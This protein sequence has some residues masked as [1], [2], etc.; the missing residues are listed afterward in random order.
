MESATLLVR[1]ARQLLTLHGPREPRR[2]AA[3]RE[4]GIIPNGAVLMRDGLIEQVGPTR[5]VVN[6]AAARGA[7][8]IDAGGRI[9]LP[10]FVD[11]HTHLVH[12]GPWLDD[13]EAR[14]AGADPLES[15]TGWKHGVDSLRTTS[16]RRLEAQAQATLDGI[17]RHGTTTVEAKSGYGSDPD[18]DVKVL[19]VLARLDQRPLDVL[20]T[21]LAMGPLWPSGHGRPSAPDLDRLCAQYLPAVARRKIAAG[22]ACSSNPAPE[23]W[24]PQRAT[25]ARHATSVSC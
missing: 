4:L 3:L 13:Y 2:G 16:V 20:R 22:A 1:G 5:R 15:M 11:S 25:W 24:P 23:N 21:F 8:E 17:A 18:T 12:G 10:G 6:L 14:L 9:V 7:E 19:R